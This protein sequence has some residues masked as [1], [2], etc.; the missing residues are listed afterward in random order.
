MKIR[1]EEDEVWPHLYED[2]DGEEYEVP[3]DLVSRWR[4]IGDIYWRLH[5]EL[6]KLT[7][8]KWDQ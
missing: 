1:L 6:L 7:T 2:R 8:R 4:E 5:R 3:D